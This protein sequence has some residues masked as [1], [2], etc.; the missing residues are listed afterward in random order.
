[1]N[2]ITGGSGNDSIDGNGGADVIDAGGGND[3]VIYRGTETSIDG[4]SGADTLTLAV[5]GGITAVNFS[6]AAGNDQTT[7]DTVSVTNFETLDAGVATTA[8]T[9]TGSAGGNN[10]TTGSGNDII[11]GGGGG[12][13]ITAGAGNDTVSYYGSENAIDGGTGTNTLLLQAAA[14][15]NL[16]NTDQTTGDLTTVTNFQNVD[17]SAIATGMDMTGSSAANVITGGSGDDVIDGAGGAD[18]IDAGGGNDTV[19]Y[20]TGSTAISGGTGTN[21]LILLNNVTVNLANADQ[22]SGDSANVTNFQNVDATF[23]STAEIDHGLVRRE[24]HHERQRK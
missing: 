14:T 22:T 10:I 20:R 5:L 19:F 7:G 16:G 21:T 4:G 24:H 15:I 2:M 17:G 1:M 13:I 11:D 9:V 6:V 3:G 12:D 23:I 18:T 8:L